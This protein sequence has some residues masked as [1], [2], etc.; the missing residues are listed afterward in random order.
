M[1]QNAATTDFIAEFTAQLTTTTTLEKTE[2][3]VLGVQSTDDG[4]VIVALLLMSPLLLLCRTNSKHS[5]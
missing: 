2:A 3:L 5:S 4:P 1:A